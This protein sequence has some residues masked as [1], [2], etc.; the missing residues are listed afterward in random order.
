MKNIFKSKKYKEQVKLLESFEKETAKTIF[1]RLKELKTEAEGIE[2]ITISD[3]EDE[4]R[5]WCKE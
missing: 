1:K 2:V 5:K 4:E 3:L